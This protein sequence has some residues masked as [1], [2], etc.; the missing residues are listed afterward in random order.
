MGF[1]MIDLDTEEGRK[2]YD[3]LKKTKSVKKAFE[4]EQFI[5]K[6]APRE[7]AKTEAD[8]TPN[9]LD[10]KANAGKEVTMKTETIMPKIPFIDDDDDIIIGIGI[11]V[12]QKPKIYRKGVV[13]GLQQ[14]R[15]RK[16]PNGEVM[17]L[18]SEKSIVDI[19]QD[20]GE[21]LKV[22][23]APNRIGYVMKEYIKE[24]T[25]GG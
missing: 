20:D 24:Y 8:K 23:T 3:K 22:E 21:W 19:L 15:V 18:I 6:L 14:L 5:E 13:F 7:E 10:L 16:S 1:K 4:D 17:Y 11:P 25:E 12:Q 9:F 2:R